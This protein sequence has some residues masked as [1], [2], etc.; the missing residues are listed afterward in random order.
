M[1]FNL[2]RNRITMRKL[3]LPVMALVLAIS[4]KKDNDPSENL[5]SPADGAAVATSIAVTNGEKQTGTMPAGTALV[6]EAPSPQTV[7]TIAGK[8]IVIKPVLQSGTATGYHLQVKGATGY[9]KINI[10]GGSST[11]III[12][13][14]AN[15]QT[16]VFKIAYNA[17]DAGNN[18]S[19]TVELSIQIEELAGEG[20]AGTWKN[21]GQ[22]LNATTWDYNVYDLKTGYSY[23][24]NCIN[25]K[26][27]SLHVSQDPYPTVFT[28][29]HKMQL[30]KN[31]I[32]FQ[33]G[34]TLHQEYK[35]EAY[36]IDYGLSTCDNVLYKR[37][38]PTD[39]VYTRNNGWT[40]NAST[41]KLSF[42][43]NYELPGADPTFSEEFEVLEKS[44]TKLIVKSID[45]G[46]TWEYT[47]Q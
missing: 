29:L 45:Y 41:K 44:A 22:K 39:I 3:L 7:K 33:A 34:Y 35:Q 28:P 12:Q 38:P 32:I 9:F 37:E 40:Y 47:K 24:F 19:N 26:I 21:T 31:E 15:I 20:F 18:V 8:Y 2:N 23:S 6:L 42:L 27:G 16:G 10:S 17:F 46:Y 14:P 13:L 36:S 1:S 25:N 5:I 43:Y 4:C 30:I 11:K